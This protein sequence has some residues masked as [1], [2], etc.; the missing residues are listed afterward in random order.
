MAVA[1]R[2]N[3]HRKRWLA[4]TVWCVVFTG[5]TAYALYA[6]RRD[7][8]STQNR[9][10]DVTAA[11]I[12][13]EIQLRDQLNRNDLQTIGARQTVER[14]ARN[15]L[16]VFSLAPSSAVLTPPVRRAIFSFFQAVDDLNRQQVEAGQSALARTDEFV[17]RLGRL[18]RALRC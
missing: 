10:C 13:S 4:L 7:A 1:V 9:F 11:F 12:S 6:Q 8:H 16:Y 17:D 5:L 2:E 14:A 18:K 15:G 3:L